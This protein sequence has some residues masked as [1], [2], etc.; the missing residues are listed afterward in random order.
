MQPI[1]NEFTLI[2]LSMY[3]IKMENILYNSAAFITTSSYSS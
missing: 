3:N 2:A 1:E